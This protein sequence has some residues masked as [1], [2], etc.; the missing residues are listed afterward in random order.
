MACA[1]RLGNESIG[2]NAG[3]NLQFGPRARLV[4]GLYYVIDTGQGLHKN[5]IFKC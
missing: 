5:L 4:R 1:L 2:K 3:R